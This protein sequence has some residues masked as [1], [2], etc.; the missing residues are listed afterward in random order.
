METPDVAL[1]E[2]GI[3][4]H[5]H[6]DNTTEILFTEYCPECNKESLLLSGRCKTCVECG[7]SSCDL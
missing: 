7:W 2:A 1:E 3:V 4:L 5:L 6:D